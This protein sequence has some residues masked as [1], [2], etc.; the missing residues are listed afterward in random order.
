MAMS[1]ADTGIKT[2]E[3]SR[4]ELLAKLQDNLTSHK[5]LYEDAL[6]GYHDAK[7]ANLKKLNVATNK[8]VADNSEENRKAVHEAYHEFST[9]ERPQDHSDSYLLAIDM[10]TWEKK[11]KVELSISDFQCYVRDNWN[12]KASFHNSVS[13]YSGGRH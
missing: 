6:R 10:M 12:W 1:L 9:L 8:A 7:V 5:A 13:N 3:V 4:T 2:V 11:D